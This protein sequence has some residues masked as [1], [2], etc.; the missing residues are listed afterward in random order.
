MSLRSM[1]QAA[2]SMNQ[3]QQQMDMIGHNMANSATPGYKSKQAEFSSLLFQQM[4]NV[5]APESSRNRLT[6]EGFRIGTGARIGGLHPNM[7]I[8]SMQTT[9]RDLDVALANEHQF[10]QVMVEENGVEDV[11]YT[12]DGSF[13]LQPIAGGSEVV[14]VTSDGNQV[15]GQNGP[16]RFDSDQVTNMQIT[17][18][19]N[20]LVDRNG[21]V[22][23]VGQLAIVG[24]E[25]VRLLEADGENLYRLP[26]LGNLGLNIADIVEMTPS[27]AGM[28]ESGV[29]EMSNVDISEQMTQLINAQ[30]SYQFNARTMTTADQMQ[31]LINQMR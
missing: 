15:I 25:R 21:Q 6:P 7:A 8:G 1:G 9:E 28:M 14:L 10:F 22:E 23:Q 4:Q 2:V 26:D 18:E 27:S 20:I 5:A 3:L 11:R 31:G 17:S 13:Y 24:I 19:G 30:R 16:I 12:R 29:L